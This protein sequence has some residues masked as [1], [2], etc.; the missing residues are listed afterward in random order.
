MVIVS[1]R[2]RE[3][4]KMYANVANLGELCHQITVAGPVPAA[5][6]GSSCCA[7]ADGPLRKPKLAISSGEA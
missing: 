2:Q 5:G 4:L 6:P 1:I 3:R 7:C